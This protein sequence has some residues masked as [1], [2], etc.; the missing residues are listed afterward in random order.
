MYQ[1]A[2]DT[3]GQFY[4]LKDGENVEGIGPCSRSEALAGCH[5]S[6]LIGGVVRLPDKGAAKKPRAETSTGPADLE[7]VFSGVVL[8]A[9]EQSIEKLEAQLAAGELD[10][11]LAE[12]L[13][14]EE[15]G[16]NRVGAISA[17]V[18]RINETAG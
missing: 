1:L 11:H 12:L 14:A 18:S 3:S 15:A 4:L 5:W 8:E 2:K 17:I 16:G 13:E 9:L 7:R 6:K 10:A